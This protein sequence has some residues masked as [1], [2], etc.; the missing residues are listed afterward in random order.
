MHCGLWF[1]QSKDSVCISKDVIC[2][3]FHSWQEN[4]QETED[5]L[6]VS[7]ALLLLTT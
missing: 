3:Y 4:K 7:P 1:T 5:F 2:G 6:T